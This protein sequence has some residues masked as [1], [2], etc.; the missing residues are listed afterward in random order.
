MVR[1]GIE[2]LRALS[3]A[4]CVVLGDRAYYGRFGFRAIGGLT[5]YW[6]ISSFPD[7]GV[8]GGCF[9]ESR[10]SEPTFSA[11]EEGRFP[12]VTLPAS[13]RKFGGGQ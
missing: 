7:I 11:S 1:A 5:L 12:W 4:G 13:W 6:F 9:A 3:A 2:Q 8:A 10:M